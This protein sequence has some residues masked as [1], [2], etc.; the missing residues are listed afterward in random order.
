MTA[1]QPRDITVA[2]ASAILLMAA[3][4]SPAAHAA[5]TD[6]SGPEPA[7]AQRFKRHAYSPLNPHRQVRNQPDDFRPYLAQNEEDGSSARQRWQNLSPEQKRQYRQ[8]L[9]RWKQLTPEQKARIKARHDRFKNLPPE[10]Q[11][12]IRNNW[13]RYQQLDASERRAVREKY[14]RWQ[15]L[16]EEQKQRIRERRRRFEN[17]TPEQ[18]ERLLEKRKR[19]QNLS[20]EK[21]RQLRE[22]YRKRRLHNQNGPRRY[23][24]NQR[25]Q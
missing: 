13:R 19:W 21:K 10:Q 25:G 5:Q 4:V 15:N 12:R 14:K 7:T 17:M 6:V 23:N 2:F 1:K 9:N 11:Q 24:R 8:R 16:S 20:P 22:E 18:R 3:L